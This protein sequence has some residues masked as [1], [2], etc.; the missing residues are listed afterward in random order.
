MGWMWNRLSFSTIAN[1]DVIGCKSNAISLG[2]VANLRRVSRAR[3]ERSRG[4]YALRGQ[5]MT[6]GEGT[7]VR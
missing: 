6:L 5:F 2:G 7:R 1:G 4:G 3:V